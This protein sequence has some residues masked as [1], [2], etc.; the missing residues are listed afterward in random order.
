MYKVLCIG[1]SLLYALGLGIVLHKCMLRFHIND[2]CAKLTSSCSSVIEKISFL[3]L[4][5][6]LT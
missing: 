5:R 1:S 3:P 4:D 2:R 6:I